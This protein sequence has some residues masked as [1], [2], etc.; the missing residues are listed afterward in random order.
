MTAGLMIDS[1]TCLAAPPFQPEK[2]TQQAV[3]VV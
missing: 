3:L 1:V 2:F